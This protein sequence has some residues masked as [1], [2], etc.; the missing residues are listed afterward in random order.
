MERFVKSEIPETKWF[1]C[2]GDLNLM[3]YLR[4]IMGEKCWVD[5]LGDF[6]C[7]I[8]EKNGLIVMELNKIVPTW[9]NGR[10]GRDTSSKCLGRCL[11]VKDCIRGHS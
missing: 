11:V 8:F 4:E 1:D 3:M 7:H 2:W 10:K 9:C 6:F 5:P